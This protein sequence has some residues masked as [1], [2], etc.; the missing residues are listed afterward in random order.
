MEKI[1]S[2]GIIINALPFRDYDC[3]LTLFTPEEGLIKLFIRAAYSSKN[4]KGAS[5]TPL[6]AVDAVY[7]KGRG[8]FFTSHEL[9][10][11]NHH[12]DLRKDLATLNAACDML[13]AISSTQQ[14][15]KAAPELYQLLTA[16]LQ[17]LPSA[18]SPAAIA[19]SFRL[20]LL[21]YEGI[22]GLISHCCTCSCTLSET[23]LHESDAF[24]RQHAPQGASM[25]TGEERDTIEQLAFSRDFHHLAAITIPP[26]LNSKVAT[27][28]Q[29]HL[30]VL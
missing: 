3:I 17:R 7:S 4:G 27:L 11:A 9:S 6:T 14:P 29:T 21:R 10:V 25:L 18:P 12:L 24:C 15:G 30:N 8:D 22:L 26:T 28:F 20:K 13:Q 5:I 1:K 16:Y 2:Q 23:W 19:C